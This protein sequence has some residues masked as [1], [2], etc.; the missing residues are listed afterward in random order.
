MTIGGGR[1]ISDPAKAVDG[2][3]IQMTWGGSGG[4][5]VTWGSA[6]DFRRRRCPTLSTAAGRT[7]VLGFIYNA[8][9]ASW[10]CVGSALGF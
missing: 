1:T 8:A 9:L 3:R 10:L 5:T 4:F 7:D 6:Y 2:Q